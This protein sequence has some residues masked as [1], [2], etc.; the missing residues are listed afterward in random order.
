MLSIVCQD[1]RLGDE[2]MIRHCQNK[3]EEVSWWDIN[4]HNANI[5]ILL[6][7]W[8]KV[9]CNCKVSGQWNGK[10]IYELFYYYNYFYGIKD[11]NWINIHS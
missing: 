4:S 11:R 1:P 6:T 3:A 9:T 10:V 7:T 8:L 5:I 2:R